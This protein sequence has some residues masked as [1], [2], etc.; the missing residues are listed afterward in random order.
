MLLST[1][2]RTFNTRISVLYPFVVEMLSLA[3]G[4]EAHLLSPNRAMP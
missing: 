2:N 4:P 1:R 3:L